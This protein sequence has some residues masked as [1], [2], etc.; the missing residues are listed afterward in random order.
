MKFLS[1]FCQGYAYALTTIEF[2]ILLN[3]IIKF[4]KM[5][6]KRRKFLLLQMPLFILIVF[7]IYYCNTAFNDFMIAIMLSIIVTFNLLIYSKHLGNH[8]S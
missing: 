3:L 1:L 4:N 5:D 2:C 6:N 8:N 7:A